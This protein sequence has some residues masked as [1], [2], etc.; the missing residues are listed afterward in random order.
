M[1]T[2]AEKILNKHAEQYFE[3]TDMDGNFCLSKKEILPAMQEY[4]ELYHNAKTELNQDHKITLVEIIVRIIAFIPFSVTVLIYFITMY[5][6]YIYSFIRY[7]GETVNYT[8]NM[9]RKTIT[10][11]FMELKKQQNDK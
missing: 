11:V 1:Q 6:K 7:G 3:T 8:K 2:P 9:N 5:L 4:A 10:D